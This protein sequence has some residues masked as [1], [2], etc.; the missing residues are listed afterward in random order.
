[1]K[2]EKTNIANISKK[3]IIVKP[4]I[5]VF[6]GVRSSKK[7]KKE[8]VDAHHADNGAVNAS[9]HLLPKHLQKKLRK[10]TNGI[11]ECVMKYSIP[12]SD[13]S[14]IMK[15]SNYSKMKT[16][17]DKLI[18]NYKLFV[19]DEIVASY[20]SIIIEMYDS[21]ACSILVCSF[22]LCTPFAV[23]LFCLMGV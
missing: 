16:D 10:H 4:C 17:V 9:V 15:A 8:L 13:G 18:A 22:M 20:D 2:T 11:R 6:M 3:V 21:I 19:Q 1:M 14:R 23:H 12:Y 7:G 5:S